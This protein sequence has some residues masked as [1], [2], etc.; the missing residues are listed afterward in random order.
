MRAIFNKMEAGEKWTAPTAKTTGKNSRDG[1]SE[2]RESSG[3]DEK[4]VDVQNSKR[5]LKL[6]DTAVGDGGEST[7]NVENGK[8]KEM[9]QQLDN[10]P[11]GEQVQVTSDTV[12]PFR[13]CKSAAKED[14]DRKKSMKNEEEER[15]FVG[16]KEDPPIKEEDTAPVEPVLISIILRLSPSD[17]K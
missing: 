2:E 4:V 15:V 9:P 14:E 6:L 5:G 1:V 11:S 13:K 10:S 17:E 12:M 16:D 8:D 7:G 3:G